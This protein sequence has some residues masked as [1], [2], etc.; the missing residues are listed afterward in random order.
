AN[1]TGAWVPA[2][3]LFA[4]H[5]VPVR[6]SIARNRLIQADTIALNSVSALRFGD[7]RS[8]AE[9]LAALRA[10][11][12]IVTAAIY[13]GDGRLFAAYPGDAGTRANIAQAIAP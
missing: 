7:D 9:T 13:S 8:A 5:L 6:S 3:A 12:N 10:D 4:Y 1:A 11:R 2:S